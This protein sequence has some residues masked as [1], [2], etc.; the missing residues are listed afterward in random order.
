MYGISSEYMIAAVKS[1]GDYVVF[2]VIVW[3]LVVL[4]ICP[5]VQTTLITAK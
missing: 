4:V 5:I 2:N 3:V 1:R